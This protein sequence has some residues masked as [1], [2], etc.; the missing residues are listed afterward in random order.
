MV[1]FHIFYYYWSKENRLLYPRTSLFRG[2]L[3]RGSTVPTMCLIK[4]KKKLYSKLNG[5]L[6]KVSHCFTRYL[7]NHRFFSYKKKKTNKQIKTTKGLHTVSSPWLLQ[8]FPISPSR[9]ESRLAWESKLPSLPKQIGQWNSLGKKS[10]LWYL[11]L[12]ELFYF[13]WVTSS[14][15]PSFQS[16]SA[17]VWQVVPDWKFPSNFLMWW[18]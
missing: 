8:L 14:V 15:W 12:R 17:P 13:W 10:H 7:K 3:Y 9:K 11:C 18:K 16:L 6:H 1:L 5:I 4:K 2:S